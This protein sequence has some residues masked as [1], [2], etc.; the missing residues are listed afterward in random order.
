M[1]RPLKVRLHIMSPVHIGCDDVYEPTSFVIDV[2]KKK[3][4]EF[5][6]LH[7]IQALDRNDREEL[8]RR[9][10]R[11]NLLD[12]FKFIKAKYNIVT[13]GREVEISEELS[14]HYNKNFLQS[15]TFNKNMVI[16]Q[17]TIGKTAYNAHNGLPY[18]PGS[19]LKGALRTAYLSSLCKDQG[20]EKCWNN[21][22]D[23]RDL[24]SERDTYDWIGKKN[25][26]NKLEKQLLGGS[27]DSDPFSLVKISDFM[28]VENG[29]TRIV[30][31]INKK[32][33]RSD[34]PTRADSG[35]PQILEV[36]KDGS[37]FEGII[38]IQQNNRTNRAIIES[39][40]LKQVNDFYRQLFDIEKRILEEIGAA[41]VD[42]SNFTKRLNETAFLIRLGRHSGAEAVTIE[43]NRH[44]KIMQK[45]G[46]PD[47]YDDHASTIW[48]ASDSGNPTTNNKLQPFA[49]AVMEL[50][51][52]DVKNIFPVSL[53]I[54]KHVTI[55]TG[56]K[57]PIVD[58]KPPPV[59]STPKAILW[60]N[61][62]V[63][64]SPGNATLTAIKDNKKAEITLLGSV[65]KEIV[66]ES[67]HKRL[68]DKRKT[69]VG[70]VTVEPIGGNMFRI[71]KIEMP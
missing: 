57:T 33:K 42:I 48:L 8:S 71:I 30:Y 43:K 40:F 17:F 56:Q 32:K 13:G 27:F 59:D 12:I 36:I 54:E 41:P 10:M 1:E 20:I 69:V 58:A 53:A 18:I 66:P 46:E 51:P 24:L 19:S 67:L 11:D 35:P 4:I 23:R 25:V 5:D 9:C 68:F 39:G 29:R 49:W 65:K 47:K 31:A 3:L 63:R 61:A 15:K 44:I 60:E 55:E 16:N 62:M 26:A 37:L 7:F 14:I 2:E 38:N 6:P 64:W 70:N 34:K 21:Y 28:P 22:L 45:K 52:L 50:L